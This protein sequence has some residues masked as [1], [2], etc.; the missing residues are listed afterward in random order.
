MV[1][2]WPARHWTTDRLVALEGADQHTLTAGDRR[3]TLLQLV[4][5]RRRDLAGDEVCRAAW[6]G[7]EWNGTQRVEGRQGRS[8]RVGRDLQLEPACSTA[9][10]NAGGIEPGST[11]SPNVTPVPSGAGSTR[12]PTVAR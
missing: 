5:A 7:P 1:R 12:S 3:Q 4:D 11:S 9:A 10:K 8:Q 2:P 6:L